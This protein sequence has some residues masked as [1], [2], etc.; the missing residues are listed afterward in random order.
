M[1]QY[2]LMALEDEAAH[3]AESPQAMARLIERRAEFGAELRRTGALRDSGRLRPS[4]EGKRVSRRGGRLEVQNGPF[5]GEEKTLGGYYWVEANGLDEAARLAERCPALPTDELDVRPLMKGS[6]PSDKEGKSGKI[7]GC[8]VLGNGATEA[9]WV[10]VMDRIDAETREGFPKAASLGGLRLQPPRSGRHVATRGERRATFDGPF[11]ESKE[12]IGGIFFLRMGSID[13]VVRWAAE[14]RFIV[15]GALE[16]REL[17][18][19]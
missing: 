16:I 10:S 7:F 1:A 15:H 17:W 18:R 9:E 4:K 13:E 3:A 5:L 11:L 12:V 19:I 14:T 2:L 8:A 6:V